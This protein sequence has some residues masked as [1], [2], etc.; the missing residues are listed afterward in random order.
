MLRR[1]A[2]FGIVQV[3]IVSTEYDWRGD[4]QLGFYYY[5]NQEFGYGHVQQPI[6]YSSDLE[7]VYSVTFT[8]R[9][10][11]TPSEIIEGA[12][13]SLHRLSQT[14]QDVVQQGMVFGTLNVGCRREDALD[15]DKELY[16]CNFFNYWKYY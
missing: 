9:K 16:I 8:L 14:A 6:K 12:A 10:G 3:M 2:I 5:M 1:L 13:G 15:N 4:A 11:A 7:D